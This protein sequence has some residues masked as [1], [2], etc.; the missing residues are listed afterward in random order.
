MKSRYEEGPLKNLLE[1]SNNGNG[2]KV[3]EKIVS[4]QF[5]HK[6]ICKTTWILP[7]G[8]AKSQINHILI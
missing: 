1:I 3:V 7:D 5:D 4:T 6:D 2:K 8:K